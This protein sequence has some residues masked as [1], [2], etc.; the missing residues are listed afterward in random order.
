MLIRWPLIGVLLSCWLAGPAL[1]DPRT[2]AGERAYAAGRYVA[3]AS[4][5][6]A[7]AADG[8]PKAQTYLGYMSQQG[9][10]TPKDFGQAARWF[11]AAAVNGEPDAQYF[12]ALLYD[13]GLGVPRDFVRAYVWMDAAAAHADG[14]RR[15]PWARLRDTIGGKLS[16]DELGR[17]QAEASLFAGPA[18]Q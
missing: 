1:A 7:P 6:V 13:R 14:R 16:Y 3:A 9:L 8:D 17:A 12:L 10:G 15:E 4:R 18:L 11:S 5:F 2:R